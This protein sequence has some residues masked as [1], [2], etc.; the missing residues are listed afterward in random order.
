M[1]FGLDETQAAIRDHCKKMLAEQVT[2][3]SLKALEADADGDGVHRGAWQALARSEMLGVSLP[4]EHGGAGL[5]LL[6]LCLLL[7]QVGRTAAPV[8]VVPTVVMGAMPIA[9]FGTEAQRAAWLPKVVRGELMLTAALHEPGSRDPAAP[10]T[11]AE[12]VEGGWRLSGVRH[13]VPAA[14]VAA[15]VLVPAR[16]DGGVG[17]FLVDPRGDGV[18]LEAQLGT[19]GSRLARLTLDGAA[20]EALGEPGQGASIVAWLVDRVMLAQCAVALGLAEQAMFMTANYSGQREQFGQP[21]GVFQ[22]VSQ[23]MGDVYIDVAAMKATLWQAAWRLSEGLEAARELTIA[24]FWAS[25]GSHRVVAA[26]QHIHGGMGFDRDYPLHRFFL[27]AKQI[28]FTLGG[29]QGQLSRLGRMIAARGEG[30][31]DGGL[32]S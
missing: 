17:V 19:D 29:A 9:E 1:N 13:A 23:R 2:E 12:A 31:L 10:T 30:P 15:R 11:T 28:E 26:A 16:C 7:Q 5:G 14:H 21:I 24:R 20:G 8:P 32:G 3:A 4:A 25:E 22:A 18:T 6:E 27:K